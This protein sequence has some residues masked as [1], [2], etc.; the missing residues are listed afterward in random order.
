MNHF[1]S[2]KTFCIIGIAS[3]LLVP[4]LQAR[5]NTSVKNTLT[6][7]EN[8]K[9]GSQ[10]SLIMPYAF[11]SESMG[12]TMGVG[13][14]IKGY[15]QEQLLLGAAAF[16]SSDKAAALFLGM[17]DFRPSFANR[18]FLSAQGMGGHYPKNRAY[19]S[20]GFQADTIRPGSND[21]D[22][23]DYV[24]DSGYD[25]W[26]D[27]KIEFVM[28]WG[29]SRNDSMQHYKIKDGLL[30]SASVGG[31]TWNPMKHGVT[32]LLLRQYNRY[33]SFELGNGQKEATIHPVQIAIAYNNTDFPGN[34][35]KGSQQYIGITHDFSWMESPYEWTFIEFE[36]SKYFSLG[37]SDWARQRIIALNFWTGDTPTW[38]EQENVDGSI[39]VTDRSPFYEG[40]TLGG[41]YRM[42]AYPVDRFND[43]S[44]IY[45]GAEYR[46]TLDWNPIGNISWLRFLKSD[47]LQLVAFGEGGRVAND[48]GDL[49]EDWKTDV[50][51]GIR[52]MFSGAVVRFDMAFSDESTTG[53]VMFGHPF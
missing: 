30:Q 6:R 13:A 41:F 48:Y 18:F 21:S 47:W 22:V 52:S 40:A 5:P 43:R 10:N 42:R 45:A 49:F 46:Y 34:P 19:T 24:E 35:S 51:F 16:G 29:S 4:T 50:G 27:F 7:A 37:K 33:R 39:T 23:D 3:L 32:T 38:S 11:S 12:F 26:T 25:N 53:W 36:A 44:V 2:L 20:V 15:G 1:I 14:G 9:G 28:P 8:P 31:D 17:W